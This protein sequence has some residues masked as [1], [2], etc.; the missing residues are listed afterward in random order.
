MEKRLIL[1]GLLCGALAGL[2]AFAFARIFA[3]PQID[4]AIAFEEG[5]GEAQLALDAAAGL[6]VPPEEGAVFTRAV[7][8]DVGLGIGIVAL[9]IALGGLYAVAFSLAYGRVGATRAR[10]LALYLALGGFLTVYF[11]PFLKYPASPPAVG[12]DETIEQR[13]ILYLSMVLASVALGILAV[14]FGRWLRTRHST[15]TA[16]LLAGAA[17]LVAVA[18]LIAVLPSFGSLSVGSPETETPGPLLDPGGNIVYEAFPADVLYFFRL[19]SVGAQV[20]LWGAL[21]LAFGPLAARLLEPAAGRA[22]AG[23]PAA[24]ADPVA[25]SAS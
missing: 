21:G 20:I 1:R 17:F 7:Q 23:V 4:K 13:G 3:E 8:A 12:D 16:T 2:L 5:R 11:V 24:Q 14:W 6:A 25:G 19:Y 10:A 18:V 9:A 22:R 15:W